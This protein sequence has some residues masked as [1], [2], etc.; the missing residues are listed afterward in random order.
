MSRRFAR[1][2]AIVEDLKKGWCLRKRLVVEDSKD[3]A[4]ASLL[5]PWHLE[6]SLARIGGAPANLS[7]LAPRRGLQRL[8][9]CPQL[10]GAPSGAQ[11]LML[12][13]YPNCTRIGSGGESLLQFG[14]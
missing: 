13:G 6:D 14:L 2:W 3:D 8:A 7:G 11:A 1:N 10:L 9:G 5:L 12:V 4:K